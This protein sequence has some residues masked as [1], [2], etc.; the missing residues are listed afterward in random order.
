MKPKQCPDILMFRKIENVHH[1]TFLK[2]KKTKKSFKFEF[3]RK[4]LKRFSHF[5]I[6]QRLKNIKYKQVRCKI[7]EIK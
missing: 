2:E 3:I 1:E 5:H 6:S 7:E 4:L